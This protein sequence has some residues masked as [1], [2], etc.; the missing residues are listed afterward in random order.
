MIGER[1]APDGQHDVFTAAGAARYLRCDPRTLLAA[2]RRGDIAAARLG[3]T[4]RIARRELDRLLAGRNLSAAA[5]RSED[6]Q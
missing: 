5:T 2:I 3:R 1:M 6:T 4:Y